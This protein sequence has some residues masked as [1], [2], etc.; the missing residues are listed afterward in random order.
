MAV[1]AE[2]LSRLR[3]ILAQK[4]RQSVQ[5]PQGHAVV[6][7]SPGI[8]GDVW[9]HTVAT[10]SRNRLVPNGIGIVVVVKN[11]NGPPSIVVGELRMLSLLRLTVQVAHVP[12]QPLLQPAVQGL[13]VGERLE[14]RDTAGEEAES[15]SHGLDLG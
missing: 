7:L 3:A 4:S 10:L 2:E 5:P 15:P 12:T 9:L 1:N 14:R 8:P 13:S 11:N 6:V